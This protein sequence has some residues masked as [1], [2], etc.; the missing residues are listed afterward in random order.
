MREC[1]H[2]KG[3]ARSRW[4]GGEASIDAVFVLLTVVVMPAMPRADVALP[5]SVCPVAVVGRHS[6]PHC[7]GNL[8]CLVVVPTANSMRQ[9]NQKVHPTGCFNVLLR[10]PASLNALP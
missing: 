7:L 6:Y 4:A 2:S 10:C 1:S 8:F 9:A 3:N 5:A